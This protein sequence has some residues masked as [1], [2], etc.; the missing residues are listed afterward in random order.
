MSLSCSEC[1]GS[2]LHVVNARTL[3][4]VHQTLHATSPQHLLPSPP[5]AH[6]SLLLLPTTTVLQNHEVHYCLVTFALAVRLPGM[7][8]PRMSTGL[9]TCFRVSPE[10]HCL[11]E[12]FSDHSC[13][14]LDTLLT[15]DIFSLLL[16][17]FSLQHLS[18]ANIP[19]LLLIHL[20]YYPP[21]QLEQRQGFLSQ[22]LSDPCCPAH[23]RCSINVC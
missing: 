2:A 21:S 14:N 9:L 1:S 16:T 4:A 13:L 18:L 20:V 17:F 7:L 3:I 23:S 11:R 10:C 5:T 15:L 22:S 19:C 12:A 6:P 8:F